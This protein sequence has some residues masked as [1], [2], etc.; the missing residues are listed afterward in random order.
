[1]KI[2]FFVQ[3]CTTSLTAKLSNLS[4]RRDY[5]SEVFRA[6]FYKKSYIYFD[7]AGKKTDHIKKATVTIESGVV[8]KIR[9]L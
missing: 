3:C 5:F 6:P 1:M 9:S 4:K 2:T 7:I 8:I